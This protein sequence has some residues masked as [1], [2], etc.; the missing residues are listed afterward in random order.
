VYAN[1]LLNTS[2]LNI[3]KLCTGSKCFINPSNSELN[4]ICHLLA[5]LGA[6]HIFHISGLRVNNKSLIFFKEIYFILHNKGVK[7][8]LIIYSYYCNIIMDRNSSV[9]IATSYGLDGPGIESQWGARFLYIVYCCFYFR[10]R[11][12]G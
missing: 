4:P 12:A 8:S 1:P 10:C 5:L 6:H 11:T 2:H 9:G 7:S 3:S